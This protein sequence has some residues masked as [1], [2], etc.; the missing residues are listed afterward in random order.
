MVIHAHFPQLNYGLHVFDI[1]Q[2]FQNDLV[3]LCEDLKLLTFVLYGPI[4]V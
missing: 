2:P 1:V 4:M 3:R